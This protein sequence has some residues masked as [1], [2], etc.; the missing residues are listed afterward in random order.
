MNGE[1]FH[2]QAFGY[3]ASEVFFV[4]P[5]SV[6][7]L[8]NA[9]KVWQRKYNLCYTDENLKPL[10]FDEYFAYSH[11]DFF[12]N[13]ALQILKMPENETFQKFN[14]LVEAEKDEIRIKY[15]QSK[16][17]IVDGSFSTENQEIAEKFLESQ[18]ASYKAMPEE[19]LKSLKS[20]ETDWIPKKAC[21]FL[22]HW[23]DYPKDFENLFLMNSYGTTGFID[24]S[25]PKGL[26]EFRA[27]F[28][29]PQIYAERMA[30][31][32]KSDLRS[33]E[34]VSI[35]SSDSKNKLV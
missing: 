14:K 32:V 3:P 29:S 31:K 35:A 12:P 5:E 13:I 1:I 4:N 30:D 17:W 19:K 9:L 26:E 34:S 21:E 11:N 2:H 8:H 33:V 18:K 24:E 22:W 23:S 6:K 27:H 25:F 7:E 28:E 20:K 16:K 15:I 10:T